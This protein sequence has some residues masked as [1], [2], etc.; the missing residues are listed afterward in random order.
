MGMKELEDVEY[1]CTDCAKGLGGNWPQG[2]LATFHTEKCD[3]CEEEKPVSNVG[4]WN[5]PDGETRGMRD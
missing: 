5:W 2:H 1:I 4:D 3:V